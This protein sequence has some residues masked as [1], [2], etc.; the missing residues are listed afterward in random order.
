[1][2]LMDANGNPV[3]ARAIQQLPDGSLII[4]G[5]VGDSETLWAAR[6]NPDFSIVWQATIN[7]FSG[8]APKMIVTD[9]SSILIATTKNMDIGLV[10]VKADGKIAFQNSYGG[11]GS[12]RNATLAATQDG[13]LLASVSS[14]SERGSLLVLQLARTG[15]VTW[16]KN[17]AFG[18]DSPRWD[19]AEI[20]V[21]N[22]GSSI[23]WGNTSYQGGFA[24]VKL[25]PD[26]TTIDHGSFTWGWGGISYASQVFDP[27]VTSVAYLSDEDSL[28][29]A[30]ITRTVQGPG[31]SW[32]IKV[33]M[34][35]EITWQNLFSQPVTILDMQPGTGKIILGGI[36]E[37]T[38]Q[39]WIGALHT[40]GSMLWQSRFTYGETGR[41]SAVIQDVVVLADG[42]IIA[43]G[44]AYCSRSGPDCGLILK[45][46]GS[47]SLEGCVELLPTLT[48]LASYTSAPF[49]IHDSQ[50]NMDTTRHTAR[51][52]RPESGKINLSVHR[53]CPNP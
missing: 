38:G 14:S 22:D 21:L 48:Q 49:V 31:P 40:D 44:N 52:D 11:T 24:F 32:V 47:G 23:L 50:P 18:S 51:V 27:S 42:S 20:M 15:A 2:T 25:D 17:I 43:A 29:V 10:K 13:Y 16:Q 7:D 3:A 30:G 6:F 34:D 36:W 41:L 5:E 4:A 19:S 26:G 46:D 1:M 9:D 28:L 37:E 39:P 12:E 33:G 8:V 53:V 35:G 45:L